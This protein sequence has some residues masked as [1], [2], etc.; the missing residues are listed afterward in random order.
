MEEEKNPDREIPF[1]ITISYFASLVL[2]RLAV[3]L[4]GSAGSPASVAVKTG[5]IKFYIGTNVVL[6]GYH[7]HHFYFGFMLIII[8]GWLAITGSDLISRK[9]IALIY[10]AGLGL[11]M[12]E[13]GLLLT[14]GDYYSSLSYTLSLFVAGIFLNLVYFPDF[15]KEVK[16]NFQ[17][18]EPSNWLSNHIF[19]NKKV[20]NVVNRFTEKTQKTEKL[21]L[22]FIGILNITIGSLILFYPGLVYYLVAAVFIL[23]GISHLVRT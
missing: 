2:I 1:L 14:W 6:F 18:P 20:F 15:W 8:A 11:F 5:E 7:I 22:I 19:E 16:Y 23:Q 4:A 13:I 17:E 10:G 3:T 12:D 9:K 21:S